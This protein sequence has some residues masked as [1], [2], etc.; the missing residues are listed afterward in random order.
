MNNIIHRQKGITFLGVVI[1]LAVIA[2]FVLFG[3]RLFPLYNTKFKTLSVMKYVASQPNAGNLSKTDVW[4]LF[5]NNADVQG[6][7]MFESDKTVKEV[8]KLEKDDEGTEVI[9]VKFEERNKLFD[10]IELVLVFDESLPMGGAG[11]GDE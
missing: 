6:L 1:V 9:H 11:G 8:V 2:A 7:L 10:D 5:Y 4:T 3:L